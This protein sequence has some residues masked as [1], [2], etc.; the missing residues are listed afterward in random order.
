MVRFTDAK[1]GTVLGWAH[2]AT[3]DGLWSCYNQHGRYIGAAEDEDSAADI[4]TEAAIA[5]GSE[6]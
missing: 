2:D 5:C 1:T 6:F 3:E 4:V